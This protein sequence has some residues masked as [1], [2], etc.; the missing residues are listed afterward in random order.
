MAVGNF[1]LSVN[2]SSSSLPTFIISTLLSPLF[3]L[4]HF[5]SAYMSGYTGSELRS[6]EMQIDFVELVEDP[7]EE[8]EWDDECCDEPQTQPLVY[9]VPELEKMIK[10]MK[11]SSIWLDAVMD[12]KTINEV[13]RCV[14]NVRPYW[15]YVDEKGQERF[16]DYKLVEVASKDGKRKRILWCNA[17]MAKYIY[18]CSFFVEY[19][20]ESGTQQKT[21]VVGYDVLDAIRKNNISR[22]RNALSLLAPRF[23]I[24]FETNASR[25]D[26]IEEMIKLFKDDV[27]CKSLCIKT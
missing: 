14:R 6:S 18:A 21:I 7:M 3:H 24:I 1:T 2:F 25:V 15:N 23:S 19:V 4:A 13:K 11:E 10:E 17:K 20:D 26:S 8:D 27:T 22:S 12:G 5:I 16:F 9:L